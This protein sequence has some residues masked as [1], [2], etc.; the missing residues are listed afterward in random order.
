M[1]RERLFS[2]LEQYYYPKKDILNRLPLGVP[3]EG[4][5]QELLNRRMGRRVTL[6]FYTMKG[7]PYWYVVTEKM[8]SAS[9]RVIEELMANEAPFDP[10]RINVSISPL[11][12]IYYTTYVEGAMISLQDAMTFLQSDE[13]PRDI[14][15]QM[16]LNNRRACN[17]IAGNLYNP[18]DE[19]FICGLAAILTERMDNGGGTYRMSD[20]HEIPFMGSEPYTVP[21]AAMI[22]D[23][24][25]ELMRFLQ[26][27]NVHPLIKAGIAQAWILLVRPFDEGNERLARLLSTVILLRAGYTFFGEVSL[28]AIIA[29]QS[30]AYY[31][32][33]AN[34]M[35]SENG[36][37]LT[38]F[39][40]YFLGLLVRALDE[41]KLRL[42]Q[43][44]ARAQEEERQMA[45]QPLSASPYPR[46]NEQELRPE[47]NLEMEKDFENQLEPPQ[48]FDGYESETADL[49]YSQEGQPDSAA[50]KAPPQLTWLKGGDEQIVRDK[51]DQV[52]DASHLMPPVADRLERFLD[53]GV[54]SF[55]R[56]QLIAEQ[57]YT[58]KQ[59]ESVFFRLREAG[60]IYASHREHKVMVYCFAHVER[61]RSGNG[62]YS[63]AVLDVLRRLAAS[64]TS[65]K[66]KRVGTMLLRNLPSGVLR[67]IDYEQAGQR[68]KWSKDMQF[69][70][71]MGLVRKVS[72]DEYE[73][74]MDLDEN[75]ERLLS[76][77]KAAAAIIYRQFGMET[78][79]TEMVIAT[80]NYSRPHASAMLHQFTLLGILGCKQNEVNRYQFMFTPDMHPE[81]FVA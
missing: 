21:P 72:G 36:D 65:I 78:F 48:N 6:P 30:Y 11:E 53:S 40:E 39:M 47:K 20:T 17:F 43:R 54:M 41:R 76:V 57:N 70:Q 38:Y 27:K 77:Q 29:R 23:K 58:P 74:R 79:S 14:N 1:D 16:I 49:E 66:D 34:I 62:K 45:M 80:L 35:R 7:D 60:I 15:E 42:A 12:E 8:V 13:E 28:S 64:K 52:R 26:D 44:L 50:G 2:H 71:Q 9:E 51:L 24:M 4:F 81:C 75:Y 73:I 25:R 46:R 22:P 33:V 63:N 3:M 56:E 18:V 32:A 19:T 67:R 59:I 5:W 10:Y 37:D 69:A 31:N 61:V 55:T 68:E